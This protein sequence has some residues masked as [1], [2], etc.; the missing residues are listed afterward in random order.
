[1]KKKKKKSDICSFIRMMCNE[2]LPRKH[3]VNTCFDYQI[4]MPK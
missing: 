3:V 2:K 1:M 4:A